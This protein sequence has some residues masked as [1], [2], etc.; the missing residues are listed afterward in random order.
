M[1][2]GRY[3]SL[4][5][6][7]GS[8][9]PLGVDFDK[10][11]S[12]V[13]KPATI[14]T[15]LSLDV[16]RQRAIHQLDVK[17][18]FLNDDLSETVYMHQPLSFVDNW[19]PHHGS[20]VAYLSMDDIILTASCPAL[21]Q[22]II[23]SL[24][25]EFDMTNLGALNYF[26]GI[27]ANCTP[28]GSYFIFAEAEYRGVANVVAETTWLHNLL[29]E[30]HFPLSTATLVYWDN[31]S[32]VYMS[33]NP[34]QHQRTK[35]IEIHIHF[36]RDMVTA[37]QIGI[38]ALSYRELGCIRR[39]ARISIPPIESNLAE[40]ARISAINLDDY[41]FDPLTPPPSPSSPFTMAAYQRM[42]SKM[43]PIQREEAL[44]ETEELEAFMTLWDVKPRV[45]E[46]SLETLS[47][48]KLITQLRQMC[49]DVEDRASNAQKEAQ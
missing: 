26:L 12:P 32:G 22:Q 30:L 5:V 49:E 36:V 34:V 27:S 31:V 15:V 45:K 13:V 10:T 28:T 2:T 16:S 14:Y 42:I 38:R 8:S 20:Q 21:L 40:R 17:N 4:L 37:G 23:G 25:N 19:Y 9:Q 3:K 43:D 29:R 18:A 41:Q 35:H 1:L 24:N 6:A 44:T 46:S 11:F 39:T 47:M 33:A 48:D 7:N